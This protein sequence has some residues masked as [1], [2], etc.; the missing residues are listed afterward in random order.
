MNKKLFIFIITLFA[1][2]IFVFE[3]HQVSEKNQKIDARNATPTFLFHGWGSGINAEKQIANYLVQKRYSKTI[4]K[5][6]V[7]K[8]GTVDIKGNFNNK[9]QHPIVLV[10]FDDN[11]NTNYH[12][13]GQYAKDA[14]KAIQDKYHFQNMNLIGHSMGNLTID[15]YLL[16]NA[17]SRALPVVSKVVSIAGGV[18][19][20]S[21]EKQPVKLNNIGEPNKMNRAYRDLLPLRQSYKN[22]KFKFL[23]IY[24]DLE[25]GTQSD[26]SVYNTSSKSMKYLMQNCTDYYREIKITGKD[27]SHGNLH[28]SKQVDRYLLNFLNK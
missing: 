17:R 18:A 20:V 7:H 13:N 10:Q 12:K 5:V 23:N 14:I 26:G 16:D 28:E 24:G 22:N 1:L 11:K 2:C 19:G 27:S 3:W 8:N 9:E 6:Y 4:T 15:Y 21:E 25:D